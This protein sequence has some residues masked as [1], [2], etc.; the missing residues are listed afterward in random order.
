VAPPKPARPT[1]TYV[2]LAVL[3]FLVFLLFGGPLRGLLHKRAL[4]R[5]A[6]VDAAAGPLPTVTRRVETGF[7]ARNR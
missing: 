1:R 2:L 4:V 5:V 3:V 6:T 7:P